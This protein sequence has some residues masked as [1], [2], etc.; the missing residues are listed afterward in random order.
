MKCGKKQVHV[1][2]EKRY[3]I[4]GGSEWGRVGEM[5]EVDQRLKII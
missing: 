3:V 2:V 5:G 4:A 1:D